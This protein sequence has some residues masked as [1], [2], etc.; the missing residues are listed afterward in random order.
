MLKQRLIF[1]TLMTIF[2]GGILILDG[3][4]NLPADFSATG[5]PVQATILCVLIVVLIVPGHLELSHLAAA[6]GLT[7]FRLFAIL[8]SVALATTWYWPQIF[9]ISADKY[10]AATA[11][12]AVLG[13]FLLQYIYFGTTGVLSNCG[14]N[15]FSIFYVGLLPAFFVLLRI[16]KG[17]GELLMLI[18]VIKCSDIGAYTAG[19]LWGRHK[20]SPVIS[21][22]K[23][24]EGMVGGIV[25]AVAAAVL[26]AVISGIM[27]WF[28]ATVFAVVFAF[29]GQLGDLAESL[30]KRDAERKDASA[31]VPGFG[32]LL[33]IIDSLLPAAPFA[34]LFFRFFVA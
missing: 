33:D 8:C 10:L 19:S 34:Y 13:L 6:R 9:N 12:A 5:T 20:F 23:T 17:H 21:P 11:T 29:I 31:G 15:L 16:E 4:I 3:Y 27:P 26:F 2:F 32:G 30:I 24:W 14:A 18:I 1:G 25:F 7:I 28:T 22:R